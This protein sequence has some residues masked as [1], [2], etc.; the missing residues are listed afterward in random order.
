MLA[1]AAGHTL[2]AALGTGRRAWGTHESAPEPSAP[3]SSSPGRRRRPATR[4]VP[5]VEPAHPHYSRQRLRC[6]G[7]GGYRRTGCAAGCAALGSALL[8]ARRAPSSP[9]AEPLRSRGGGAASPVPGAGRRP[10]TGLRAPPAGSPSRQPRDEG[11]EPACLPGPAVTSKALARPSRL[12]Y[13][14]CPSRAVWPW[15]SQLTCASLVWKLIQE[16]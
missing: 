15:A 4:L 8:L 14:L 10:G 12:P 13:R 1:A 2:G 16:S 3:A 9:P 7:R 11:P 6:G 5:R